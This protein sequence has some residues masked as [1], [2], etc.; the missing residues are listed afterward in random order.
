MIPRL[1]ALI[2][3]DS[4]AAASRE[5]TA[6]DLHLPDGASVPL[7]R[8]RDH[9][10]RRLRLTVSER[11]V[12]LSVPWQLSEHVASAFV[13]DHAGW[14]SAQW[15]RFRDVREPVAWRFGVL[16]ALPL[17]GVD[18]PLEWLPARSA[19]I[20]AVTS[21]AAASHATTLRFHAPLSASP[22][23]LRRAVLEF[24]AAEARAAVHRWLPA[25]LPGLPRPP[26]GFR[27]RALASLWGSLAPD[28][29]V[30]LDLALVLGPPSAFE[31]VLVHE[32]CHLVHANHSA[33][34][35]REV[36]ARCP[37]WRSSRAYLRGDAG[38]GLKARLR[39][40]ARG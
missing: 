7:L 13:Q 5:S 19:R 24:Y 30:S 34:F 20:E 29:R 4:E 40:L 2:R 39:A 22:A 11:G 1:R 26:S 6:L 28:D 32:L 27:I 12:R 17:G 3:A 35:W 21:D 23:A 9:R 38:F 37:D 15:Q 14:I 36:E 16:A 25:Y 18:A 10:V 33:A 31:Y 8:V